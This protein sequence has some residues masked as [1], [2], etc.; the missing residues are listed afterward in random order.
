MSADAPAAPSAPAG[1]EEVKYG[2]KYGASRAPIAYRTARV[3]D[4]VFAY[5]L[6]R[7]PA[8]AAAYVHVH[9]SLGLFA[10]VGRAG[11]GSMRAG[12]RTQPLSIR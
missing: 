4:D 1:D 9:I 3:P 8:R 12:A 7:L 6:V 11:P 2:L 10:S 5:I